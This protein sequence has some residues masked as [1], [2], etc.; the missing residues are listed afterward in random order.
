MQVVYILKFIDPETG[1]PKKFHHA[2][3]YCGWSEWLARRLNHHR[4]GSGSLLMRAVVHSG[5]D[6]VVCRTFVG[7]DRN[8]E[9]RIKNRK[10]L[11]K[12]CPVCRGDATIVRHW[13]SGR[14]FVRY[15]PG[16]KQLYAT[17]GPS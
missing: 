9:R 2:A 13:K 1:Q 12:F 6:F 15:K 5:L 14:W 17:Q 3:H 7:Q 4:S 8:F 16:K 10:N 11:A